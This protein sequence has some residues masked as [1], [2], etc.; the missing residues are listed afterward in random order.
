MAVGIFKQYVRTL[1]QE[2]DWRI[3]SAGIAAV[4]GYPA[5]IGSLAVC[6]SRG[7]DI[8]DHSSRPIHRAMLERF[9]LILTMEKVHQEVLQQEFTDLA[10]RIYMLSEMIGEQVDVDD[11]IGEPLQA[12]ERTAR[13]IEDWLTRGFPRILD[14]TESRSENPPETVEGTEKKPSKSGQNPV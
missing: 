2:A 3:E 4:N 9:D 1:R 6:R 10:D 5:S 13:L 14:L 11:P 12:Y 8:G 7:M